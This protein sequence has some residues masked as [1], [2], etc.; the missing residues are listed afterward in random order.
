MY[1]HT[2]RFNIALIKRPDILQK[3]STDDKIY[4]IWT[5]AAMQMQ[6]VQ[7]V[8]KWVNNSDRDTT[9]THGFDL[10][11][12]IDNVSI[13]VGSWVKKILNEQSQE[14]IVEKQEE[15]DKLLQFIYRRQCTL[16]DC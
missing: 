7:F 11:D 8:L 13:P 5:L 4:V 12:K 2:Q 16:N 15:N 10:I 1:C 6:K 14:K 3:A 9:K